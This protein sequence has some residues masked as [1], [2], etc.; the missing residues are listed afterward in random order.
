MN[1]SNASQQNVFKAENSKRYTKFVNELRRMTV[2]S[3][4]AG[5]MPENDPIT[6]SP[7]TLPVKNK[8]CGHIYDKDSILSTI[9]M[10][11]TTRSN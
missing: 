2:Q 6:C 5:L 8:K 9:E 10:N 3:T 4:T 11:P 1:E 7:I